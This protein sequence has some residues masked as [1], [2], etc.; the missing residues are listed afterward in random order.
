M[1]E[2]DP[3]EIESEGSKILQSLMREV[4]DPQSVDYPDYS[5]YADDDSDD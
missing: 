5:C 2:K 3:Q 4:E 1:T